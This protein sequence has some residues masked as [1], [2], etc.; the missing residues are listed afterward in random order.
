MSAARVKVIAE[1]EITIDIDDDFAIDSSGVQAAL[2]TYIGF[3][4]ADVLD[5]TEWE[6]V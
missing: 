1:I 5:V 2:Q 3:T 4:G 6:Q